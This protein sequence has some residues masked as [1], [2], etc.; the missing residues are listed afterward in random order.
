MIPPQ[1]HPV[2]LVY[3]A[4]SRLVAKGSTVRNALVVALLVS[5]VPALLWAF[6]SSIGH[7]LWQTLLEAYLLKLSF[8]ET[9]V[10][11]PCA[12]AY[13]SGDCPRDVVAQFV[14]RDLRAV[15]C[16][17][18]ASACL[19]SAAES[20]VDSFVSPLFWYALLGLPGAWA[21]RIANTLDGLMGF[22][23]WGKSGA[24]AAYLDTA[25]N[26]A[27]A[28]IAALFMLA[29]AYLLGHRPELK[30]DRSIESPN[31]R[32]PISAMAASLRVRLEKPGSYSVGQGELPSRDDV[33]KGLRLLAAALALYSTCLL[34]LLAGLNF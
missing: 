27:P 17:H 13:R 9:H 34:A 1:V 10:L 8:S 30:P 3:K 4:A 31:A 6:Q 21:Q 28:R 19:E 5:A 2:S 16:G 29:A 18:V 23:E 15:D 12:S 33:L 24:P 22:K 14:R 26:W 11:Y 32:W 7:G 25:L 20:F